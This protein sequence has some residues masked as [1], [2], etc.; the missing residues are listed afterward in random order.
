MSYIQNHT[1]FYKVKVIERLEETRTLI[2]NE[3]RRMDELDFKKNPLTKIILS[4]YY[5][6]QLNKSDRIKSYIQKCSSFEEVKDFDLGLVRETP[7]RIED[8]LNIKE[9]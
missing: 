8:L 4:R 7:R 5:T 9:L 6:H 1:T 3:C 2:L